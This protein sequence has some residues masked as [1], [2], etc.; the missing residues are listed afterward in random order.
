MRE[1]LPHTLDEFQVYTDPIF[2]NFCKEDDD[3]GSNNSPSESPRDSLFSQFEVESSKTILGPVMVI[4]AS[5]LEEELVNMKATLERLSK[6]SEENDVQIKHQ[7]KQIT[8]LIKKLENRS[9]KA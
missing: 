3:Y 6:E 8:D 2:Q 4:Q 1:N 7:N 9:S 5:N